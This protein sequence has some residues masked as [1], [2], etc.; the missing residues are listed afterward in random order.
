M[1]LAN[2]IMAIVSE[3]DITE[4]KNLLRRSPFLVNAKDGA[5]RTPLSVA[6]WCGHEDITE[7]L[8]NAGAEINIQD[9]Y[10][11]TPLREAETSARTAVANLLRHRGAMD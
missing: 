10:G 11:W 4:V 7:L 1:I 2:D 5:G 9:R 6:A 3:G 8:L